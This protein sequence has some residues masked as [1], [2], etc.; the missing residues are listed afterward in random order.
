AVR[1]AD[2]GDDRVHAR[3]VR[4]A[5]LREP[6]AVAIGRDD[7]RARINEG[8]DDLATNAAR[9][10]GHDRDLACE[11]EPRF[12]AHAGSDTTYVI[13]PPSRRDIVGRINRSAVCGYGARNSSRVSCVAGSTS[14]PSSVPSATSVPIFVWATAGMSRPP[15]EGRRTR[16]GLTRMCLCFSA[17]S[18]A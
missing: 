14:V 1:R 16:V 13:A 6:V 8:A 12:L 3:T 9:R 10:P 15:L 11:A 7:V 2:V 18:D 4:P 5:G 17:G